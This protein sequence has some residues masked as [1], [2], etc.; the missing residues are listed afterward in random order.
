MYIG[1]ST[2]LPFMVGMN[3]QSEANLTISGWWLSHPTEK[4]ECVS[5]DDDIPNLFQILVIKHLPM[6]HTTIQINIIP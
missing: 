6:F 2:V 3:S 1:K 4:C 5:W